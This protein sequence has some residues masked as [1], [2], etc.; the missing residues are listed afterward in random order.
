MGLRDLLKP[1]SF[2]LMVTNLLFFNID[3]CASMLADFEDSEI[4][5]KKS[6]DQTADRERVFREGTTFDVRA[7]QGPSCMSAHIIMPG[8]LS[9]RAAAFSLL[10]STEECLY[11]V[12]H[13]GD[14]TWEI[15]I[16]DSDRYRNFP[17]ASGCNRMSFFLKFP[18]SLKRM[19]NSAYNIHIGTYSHDPND[20]S[21]TLFPH[22]Y[23][24]MNVNGS[25]YWRKVILNQHPQHETSVKDEIPDNPTLERGWN[26]MDGMKRLYIQV[27][28]EALL[29]LMES[30]FPFSAAIDE[31]KFY[32]EDMQENTEDIN[33]LSVCYFGNG[34]FEFDW[35]QGS[36]RGSCGPATYEIRYSENPITNDN[37]ND[38]N[39]GA[40][41]TWEEGGYHLNDVHAEV[42]I[43]NYQEGKK[44]YFGVKNV[45]LPYVTKIDY[46]IPFENDADVNQD[47]LADISDVQLVVN[48]IL[49][50]ATNTRADVNG[51]G[52]VTISDAQA[53]VNGILN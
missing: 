6:A 27:R 37:F 18:V 2:I 3:L 21:T 24:W 23:H 50:T 51:D 15:W 4:W 34:R 13:I 44:Y 10:N 19:D 39:L 5:V 53:V 22:F 47:G 36:T 41:F 12:E 20:R 28:T 32:H 43:E 1:I 46:T 30:E 49:G 29:D 26:Y 11:D 52:S 31:I 38:S 17:E 48:V 14:R 8:V 7:S 45:S 9:S 16:Y 42:T 40:H 25:P 33:T 35:Q